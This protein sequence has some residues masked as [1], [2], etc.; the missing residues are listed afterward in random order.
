MSNPIKEQ[1]NSARE[2]AGLIRE[3]VYQETIDPFKKAL[4]VLIHSRSIVLSGLFI[5]VGNLLAAI[6]LLRFLETYKFFR[7]S[8][9]FISYFIAIGALV[10]V[11]VIE[12]ALLLASARRCSDEQSSQ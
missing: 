12:S 11:V 1:L 3:Y 7:G 8:L 9:S 10:V 2:A 6:G 4:K 5:G